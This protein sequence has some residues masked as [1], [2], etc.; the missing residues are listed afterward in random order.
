MSTPLRPVD[1]LLDLLAKDASEGLSP[2]EQQ[3][4]ETLLAE[5]DT[6][7]PDTFEPAVAA[8]TLLAESE[9]ATRS[10]PMPA[11]VAARIL[12]N[13]PVSD[14]VVPLPVAP[15]R[16]SSLQSAGWW[17]AAAC[18]VLAV[19]GWW[20]RL[21]G[22][23]STAPAVELTMAEQRE[24]LLDSG[25][26]IQAS[27]QPGNDPASTALQGD[28]VFDPVSQ[29][30]YLRFRGIPANDPRLAQ[31][32]LWIADGARAQPQPVDGG[33]FDVNAPQMTPEGDVIIPFEARLQVGRPA[34][35]VVTI[36][37]P[38]GVVVSSQERVLALAAVAN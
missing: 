25:R 37:Q 16:E 3:R 11:E 20:P 23:S 28:V 7:P 4:L 6:L 26:A 27:W 17:A 12:A 8:L 19:W 32:Q 31:Y 35:F 34:A 1:E 38:G 21:T 18:F 29:R 30:G 2:E 22:P 36:E 15:R 9:S 5:G 13:A 24:A 10:P 33:V 14:N